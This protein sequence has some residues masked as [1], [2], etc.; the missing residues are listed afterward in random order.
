MVST[1]SNSVFVCQFSPCEFPVA[2]IEPTNTSRTLS[3]PTFLS[4]WRVPLA[5]P[6]ARD[7]LMAVK[8]G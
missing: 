4:P 6:P 2:E 7:S 8:V 1:N 5:I 3:I